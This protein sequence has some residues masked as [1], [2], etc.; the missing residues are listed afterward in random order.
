MTDDLTR[1][2][3]RNRTENVGRNQD[4]D[5]VLSGVTVNWM[6]TVFGMKASTVKRRLS[7]L[8][9]IGRR[10][11]GYVYNLA[12]A[13]RYLV[14]PIFD[15]AEYIKTMKPSELPPGLQD[16]FWR[17][18][19]QRQ[20][21]LVEAQ[22]LWPTER[23]MSVLGEVWKL[24][25]TKMQLFPDNVDRAVGLTDAQMDNFQAQCDGLL[26]EVYKA[27]NAPDGADRPLLGPQSDEVEE[28][29][30]QGTMKPPPRLNAPRQ[31]TDNPRSRRRDDLI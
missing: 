5:V 18:Q 28:M 10:R 3:A 25:R 30:N 27:I 26:D 24:L 14:A 11:N 16:T 12:D 4:A 15:P 19:R 22:Q 17:A 31:E 7:G 9:P 20:D 1:H 23:V 6:A 13:A 21:W 2:L 8:D 29:D